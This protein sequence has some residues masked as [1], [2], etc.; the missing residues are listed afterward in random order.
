MIKIEPYKRVA[1]HRKPV[2]QFGL[3]GNY[4][5]EYSSLTEASIATGVSLNGI[6]L[7][8]KKMR[9]KAGNFQ[10]RYKDAE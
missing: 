10:W 3:N 4:I 6:C 5:A 8:C 9:M 2:I 7:C 1:A